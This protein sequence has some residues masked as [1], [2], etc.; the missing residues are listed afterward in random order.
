MWIDSKKDY[1]FR[2]CSNTKNERRLEQKRGYLYY[3]R[4][5]RLTL[6][7]FIFFYIIFIVNLLMVYFGS[8]EYLNCSHY[9]TERSAN[10]RNDKIYLWE[11]YLYGHPTNTKILPEFDKTNSMFYE[12]ANSVYCLGLNI[13]D[14]ENYK[15]QFNTYS[16]A[17]TNN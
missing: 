6:R 10:I 4:Y 2:V 16:W 8:W 12:S 17:V 1:L 14:W 13:F 7:Y 15:N 11:Q 5:W 3:R 9:V